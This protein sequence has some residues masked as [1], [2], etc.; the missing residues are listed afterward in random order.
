MARRR[1]TPE[2]PFT[3]PGLLTECIPWLFDRGVA[4]Y[5]GD[6]IEQFPS[7]YPGLTS[8]LHEIGLAAM[9]LVL[10]D[11]LEVEELTRVAGE[12]GRATFLLTCAPLSMDG[13]TGSA[14]NPLAVF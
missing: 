2:Q 7:P 11:N 3:R 12:L 6:C 4:V 8:P 1:D 14:V 9:G 13:A 5:S 10:L